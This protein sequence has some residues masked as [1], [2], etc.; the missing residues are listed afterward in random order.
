MIEMAKTKTCSRKTTAKMPNAKKAGATKVT[1]NAISGRFVAAKTGRV[2]KFSPMPPRLG[3]ERIQA[4]VETVV[5][6]G[7]SR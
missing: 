7:K 3:E 4:A 1:R 6:N 5:Q 2:V